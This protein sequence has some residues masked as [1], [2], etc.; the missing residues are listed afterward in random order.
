[1]WWTGARRAKGE[2]ALRGWTGQDRTKEDRKR[3]KEEETD[4]EGDV[5]G[6]MKGVLSHR[7]RKGASSDARDRSH[8]R[9]CAEK[10]KQRHTI[11]AGAFEKTAAGRLR[12]ENRVFAMI[13]ASS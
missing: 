8:L 13:E 10:G 9:G 5:V 2:R 7:R 11:G 12:G 4:E 3:K 6:C 1:M